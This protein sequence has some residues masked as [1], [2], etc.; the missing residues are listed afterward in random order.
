[1][2]F[3]VYTQLP[4]RNFLVLGKYEQETVGQSV[5]NILLPEYLIK[6]VGL[7]TTYQVD[8]RDGGYSLEKPLSS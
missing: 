3:L 7:Y 6:D 4:F 2:L 5:G 1:V 8:T